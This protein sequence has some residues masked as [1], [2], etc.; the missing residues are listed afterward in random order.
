[1]APLLHSAPPTAEVLP[2]TT[3]R[4]ESTSDRHLWQVGLG[5]GRLQVLFKSAELR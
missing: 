5:L 2:T 3:Y 4:Q 1:V